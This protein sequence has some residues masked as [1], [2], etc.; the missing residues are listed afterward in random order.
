MLIG[1]IL[2]KGQIEKA[3]IETKNVNGSNRR[4]CI[5]PTQMVWY[6]AYRLSLKREALISRTAAEILTGI[7]RV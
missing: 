6:P 3:G 5:R 1:R 2:K 7:G 4:K